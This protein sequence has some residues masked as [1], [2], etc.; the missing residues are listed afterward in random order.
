MR[1]IDLTLAEKED[2]C[3]SRIVLMSGIRPAKRAVDR[4]H[5]GRSNHGVLYLWE[6]EVEFTFPDGP[7]V[8]AYS[9]D[10]TL[11]PKGCRYCM[12][13]VAES[14]TFVLMNCE[15][16]LADGEE[17]SFSDRVAVVANDA[18]DR[19][20]A[21]IMAKLEMCSA[22]ENSAAVFRRKEL[23][24]RL[25]SHVFDDGT[26]RRLARVEGSDIVPG[27][28]LLKQSYLENIPITQLAQ[29]CGMSI[30]SFRRQFGMLYG[31]SP[32][33]Y[34]NRLRIQRARQ[35]LADGNCTVSEAACAAGFDN[36]G[37][38]SRCYKKLTGETPNETRKSEI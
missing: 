36:L 2:I 1:V 17:I 30:S 38:F 32:V 22:S 13:Y 8:R 14:T 24:Y 6:G 35:L 28:R 5:K 26:L 11:I 7:V 3:V 23:A 34:R 12:R 20:I 19:R 16:T 18:S 27:V 4:L 33:Q 21:G 25:L 9:G 10:L 29:S 37:Y 31:M 15:L